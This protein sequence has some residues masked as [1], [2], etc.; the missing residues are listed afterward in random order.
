MEIPPPSPILE[1]NPGIA[2]PEGDGS[3]TARGRGK[4]T[5]LQTR[6]MW[7]FTSPH[8][9][10]LTDRKSSNM[11]EFFNPYLQAWTTGDKGPQNT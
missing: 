11:H 5:H 6:F 3:I 2:K 4:I 8:N 7:R 9:R 1:R 10:R